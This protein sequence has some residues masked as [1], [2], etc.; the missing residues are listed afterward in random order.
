MQKIMLPLIL[1][2]ILSACS[3]MDNREYVAN[4]DNGLTVAK[5]QASLHKGMTGDQVV[6]AMGSPNI[7]TS[8]ANGTETWVYD[9]VS[10]ENIYA[11]AGGGFNILLAGASGNTGA[12]STTQKTLT[13]IVKFDANK[14]VSDVAYHQSSF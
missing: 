13:I 2:L 3:G 1:S 11:N 9:K 6:S 7:V 8:G 4:K 14:Q 5:A 10:T 12:S